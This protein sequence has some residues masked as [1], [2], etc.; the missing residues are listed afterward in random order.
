MKILR[1]V[2]RGENITIRLKVARKK[3]RSMKCQYRNYVNYRVLINIF[4][5][6]LDL[7]TNKY[8]SIMFRF[9]YK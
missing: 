4:Q 8:I 7:I 2:D 9:D 5:L 3:I 1:S 6:C